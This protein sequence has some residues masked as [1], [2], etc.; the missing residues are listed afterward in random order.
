MLGRCVCDGVRAPRRLSRSFSVFTPARAHRS[1]HRGDFPAW[2][3]RAG[4]VTTCCAW[5]WR[6][7][8]R[9]R[10]RAAGS[11]A[12]V[13]ELGREAK[14]LAAVNGTSSTRSTGCWSGQTPVAS[15]TRCAA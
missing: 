4:T 8:L 6:A 5:I 1:P 12:T 10:T 7:A 14:A 11:L 2:S 15:S 13:D 3:S 9:L